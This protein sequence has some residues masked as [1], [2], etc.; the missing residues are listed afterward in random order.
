MTDIIREYYNKNS[1]N[2]WLRLNDPYNRLELFSTM[3]M[4]KEYFPQEGKI[5]DIGSGPTRKIFNRAIKKRIWSQFNGFVRKIY[6][7]GKK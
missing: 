2:E 4:I 5:L 3:Y 7:Y 6:R 1:K